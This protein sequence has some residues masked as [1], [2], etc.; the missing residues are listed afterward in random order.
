[1]KKGMPE[2]SSSG[3]ETDSSEWPLPKPSF[4]KPA[5]PIAQQ[6]HDPNNNPMVV[7]APSTQ[8]PAAVS[9]HHVTPSAIQNIQRPCPVYAS[10]LGV[11]V[12]IHQLQQQQPPQSHQPSRPGRKRKP[13]PY[14]ESP[15]TLPINPS[16]VGR[17][18]V[19]FRSSS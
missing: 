17:A 1:M 2:S 6:Q 16:K 8:A 5:A 11:A 13:D 18:I 12:P 14:P 4:K 15:G 9:W 10:N 19:P 3:S 7:M